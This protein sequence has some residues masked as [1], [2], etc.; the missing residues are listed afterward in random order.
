MISPVPKPHLTAIT[1]ADAESVEPGHASEVAVATIESAELAA[2]EIDELAATS[3]KPKS[4][5]VLEREKIVDAISPDKLRWNNIDWLVFGWTFVMH[6]GAVAALFFF[7]WPA[8]VAF[9]VLHFLT[10]S[11]GICLGYHRYLSHK[12][13]KLT[14]VGEFTAMF[15]G[16]MS[17]EGS[18]L[19][20][21]ATHRLHH[22]RSD[23]KGDPHSPFDGSWWSHITWLFVKQNK[24]HYARLHKQYVPELID[25]PMIKFFQRFELPILIGPGIALYALG[26][27]TGWGGLSMMLWGLCMRMVV[28][29][30]ST[31][32]VNSAT[33]LWGYR[34]YDT[35]DHSR[36]LWWVAILSYGEG[37]HNNHHA[38]P[39]LAPAGHR[40]WE[41][42]VT[43]G[44]IK[45]WR[46]LGI[47]YDVRDKVP[48]RTDR[49]ADEHDYHPPTA[50]DTKNG[51][52]AKTTAIPAA[53]KEPL[54]TTSA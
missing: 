23:L 52:V 13:L 53:A 35:R 12:S 43:W 4:H 30:H 40:W 36:N 48:A 42:D 41:F 9:L 37:W 44:V 1:P 50:G 22:Q 6:V 26:E 18:P 19:D 32:F 7:T 15:C 51:T 28:A 8:F 3:P 38:H 39:S 31:W 29:Y 34:N 47:A 21:S 11:V 20:W 10:A 24:E 33:H 25:R 2:E 5:N 14:P 46:M 17:G 27:L 45:L 16:T 49:A 54:T